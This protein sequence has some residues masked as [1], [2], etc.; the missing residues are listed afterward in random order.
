M[1]QHSSFPDYSRTVFPTHGHTGNFTCVAN[2]QFFM[3]LWLGGNFYHVFVSV[4]SFPYRIVRKLVTAGG[5]PLTFCHFIPF[6]IK[7]QRKHRG[8]EVEED[9]SPA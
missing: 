9:T 3:Y 6:I 8:K 4:V 7:G 2:L 5:I 1:T